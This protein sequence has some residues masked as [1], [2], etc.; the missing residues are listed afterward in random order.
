MFVVS[1]IFAFV[2]SETRNNWN[3]ASL[4]PYSDVFHMISAICNA[5]MM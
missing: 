2:T 3:P 1:H 4:S 5:S